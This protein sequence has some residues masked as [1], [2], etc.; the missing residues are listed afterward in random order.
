MSHDDPTPAADPPADRAPAGTTAPPLPSLGPEV[1]IGV[2]L[3][4]FAGARR[5]PFD[6][7]TFRSAI[8]EAYAQGSIDE[9]LSRR[10]LAHTAELERHGDFAR[11]PGGRIVAPWD[12]ARQ[13]NAE[14]ASLAFEPHEEGRTFIDTMP[15]PEAGVM[16]GN[17]GPEGIVAAE[18]YLRISDSASYETERVRAEPPVSGSFDPDVHVVNGAAT[19]SDFVV[20]DAAAGYEIGI[21]PSTI[22]CYDAKEFSVEVGGVAVD[23][24]QVD[25]YLFGGHVVKLGFVPDRGSWQIYATTMDLLLQGSSGEARLP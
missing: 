9:E 18:P 24:R 12:P 1:I 22:A 17:W 23:R 3:A 16:G 5:L 7:A 10:L 25:V 2:E 19:Q 15:D 13:H 4:Q 14:E 11:A 21:R 20:I 8:V 6:A